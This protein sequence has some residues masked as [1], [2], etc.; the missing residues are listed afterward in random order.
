MYRE[1]NILNCLLINS[2]HRIIGLFFKFLE[3]PQSQMFECQLITYMHAKKIPMGIHPT[4]ISPKPQ[5]LQKTI[6]DASIFG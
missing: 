1:A 4:K 5:A 6:H 3:I 2:L